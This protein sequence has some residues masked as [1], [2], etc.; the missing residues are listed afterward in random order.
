MPGGFLDFGDTV[1][2]IAKRFEE[3][4][5]RLVQGV[6]TEVH[7]TAAE[8]TP[9]E[10]GKAISNWQVGIGKPPS[11]VREPHFPF[12]KGHGSG[13]PL[14]ARRTPNV[15]ASISEAAPVIATRKSEQT[16][17]VTNNLDYIGSL[18]DGSSRQAPSGFV[19]K[20]VLAGVQKVLTS[21]IL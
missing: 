7:K 1:F 14:E 17:Y 2:R 11:D 19:E 20:A 6:I 5:N 13:V 9:V 12:P 16:G 18:N 8:E 21:K 15:Q 4:T 3:E 10:T